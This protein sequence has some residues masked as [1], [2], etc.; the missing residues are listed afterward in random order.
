MEAQR[1]TAFL[2]Q[3]SAGRDSRCKPCCARSGNVTKDDSQ[4]LPRAGNAGA[5]EKLVQHRAGRSG[6]RCADAARK[7][8]V[9]PP[10]IDRRSLALH[11]Q[12]MANVRED[13]ERELKKRMQSMSATERAKLKSLLKNIEFLG[14]VGRAA[15][16]SRVSR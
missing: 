13:A 2:H 3:L 4:A 15:A 14:D 7:A 8:R 16:K 5:G 11:K 6:K 9:N 10:Q 12:L 1:A